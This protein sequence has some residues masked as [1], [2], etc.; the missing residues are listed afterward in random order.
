MP[1]IKTK[2]NAHNKKILQNTLPKNAKHC[3]CEKIE[4]CPMNDACL[5][6]ISL[7]YHATITCNNKNFKPKLYK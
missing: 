6:E 5:K 2:I 3:N 4:D 7:L 1:N